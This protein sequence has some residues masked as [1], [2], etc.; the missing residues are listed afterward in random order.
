LRK[1]STTAS[2]RSRAFLDASQPP[3]HA[4]VFLDAIPSIRQVPSISTWPEIEDATAGVLEIGFYLG[5]P[6][7][8]VI[9]ELDRVTRPLFARGDSP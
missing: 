4:R 1:L 8:Q 2:A 9:R 7:G 5:Q 3:R 6:V